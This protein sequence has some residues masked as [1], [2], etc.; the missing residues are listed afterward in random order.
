[1]GRATELVLMLAG[2]VMTGRGIDQVLAHPGA[3]QLHE[4]HVRDAREYVRL[5]EAENGA[6]PAPVPA[7]YP[8][9]QAL[10][11][12]RRA[13]PDLCIVNLETAV[14]T[15]DDA[16]PD[17]GIHYR[18]H[19]ANVA[20]L[21][22]AR[23]DCCV[24]A[25]NHVL[26]WGRAGLLE[27]LST[28]REAGLQT[29]GAGADA[30]RAW[31]GAALPIAGGRRLLVLACATCSSGV[32][33][34]WEAGEGRCGIAL[35]HDLSQASA[36]RLAGA[37]AGRRARGDRVLVSIHWG[38]NWGLDLPG[39]H[40]AFAHRLIDLGAADIVHGHS[41]HHPL[42][43]ELYRGKLILYGCGDLIND[44]EGIYTGDPRADLACLYF[45]RVGIDDGRLRG[46]DIVALQRRRFRLVAAGASATGWLERV[47][48]SGPSRLGLQTRGRWS[49]RWDGPG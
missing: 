42:P 22:S 41:S 11:E 14:T 15:A 48:N 34:E 36:L 24:L 9:G 27:T 5:A 30:A 39:A 19:P 12:I 45:A 20:C 31:S 29:A 26:D 6:I 28:L 4:S 40:R 3:P 18:M 49:L 13:A 38:A 17:K 47:F 21:R 2:D 16:W 32:P 25:N 35:L 37:V 10:A 23:I 8:W 46:L 7:R 1:M 33:A 43:V 44:Y